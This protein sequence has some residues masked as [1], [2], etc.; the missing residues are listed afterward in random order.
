MEKF[1]VVPLD[2]LTALD[3]AFPERSPDLQTPVDAIRHQAGQRSVVRFLQKKFE[4]QNDQF[5]SQSVF[6]V[7]RTQGS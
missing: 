4:E 5:I 1:P 6:N 3:E 2:L 7:Q